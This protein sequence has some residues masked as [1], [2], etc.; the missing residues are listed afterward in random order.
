VVTT[1]RTPTQIL[2]DGAVQGFYNFCGL[3]YQ[4][5]KMATSPPPK[6]QNKNTLI[7]FGVNF[8]SIL[9][10]VE[11]VFHLKKRLGQI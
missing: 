7:Y 6:K 11:F 3:S 9:K 5:N 2:P 8:T 1:T 10:K 4:K